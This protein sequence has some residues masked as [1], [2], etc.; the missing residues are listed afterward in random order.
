MNRHSASPFLS[1]PSYGPSSGFSPYDPNGCNQMGIRHLFPLPQINYSCYVT[2]A[3]PRLQFLKGHSS[4]VAV[5][6]YLDENCDDKQHKQ[7][8]LSKNLC[9]YPNCSFTASKKMMKLHEIKCHRE[10]RMKITLD[11]PEEI[12]KW[13]EERKRNYPTSSNL[14]KKEAEKRQKLERGQTVPIKEFRYKGKQKWKFQRGCF[15]RNK[16]LVV[17]NETLQP[18]DTCLDRISSN[19]K[20]P[21]EGKAVNAETKNTLLNLATDYAS[22]SDGENDTITELRKEH[23][24]ST[25]TA[26]RSVTVSGCS[27][28]PSCVQQGNKMG[29]LQANGQRKKEKNQGKSEHKQNPTNRKYSRPSLLEMLLAQD[30]K[31]ERNMILQ[32]IRYIVRKQ[33]F[34]AE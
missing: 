7:S 27:G 12:A 29:K 3:V 34:T 9:S 17:Q 14:I 4:Q 13:R 21:A 5:Q 30:I 6:Q 2:P 23:E 25:E 19:E 31:R 26:T 28:S 22:S 33:F 8:V 24:K 16:N 11:S 18:S 1:I 10:G 15:G 32:C 20:F